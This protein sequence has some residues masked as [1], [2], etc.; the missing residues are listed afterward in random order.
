MLGVGDV[1]FTSLYLAASR[2]HALPLR[3]SLLA[4]AAA[5]AITTGLVIATER[6]IPVLP[7]LGAC[8]VIAQPK[9]RTVTALDRRRGAWGLGLLAAAILIWFLKRSL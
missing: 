3:R 2:A 7:M 9:A 8:L 5:F 1:V 6:P 4:L